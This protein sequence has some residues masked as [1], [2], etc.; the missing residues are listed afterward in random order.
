VSF[1]LEYR[2]AAESFLA[3]LNLDRAGRLRLFHVLH[4]LRNISDAERTDLANRLGPFFVFRRAFRYQGRDLPIRLIVDDSL[5]QYGVL[6]V[7]YADR[8]GP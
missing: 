3:R 5:A 7:I 6:R 8:P 1:L 2:P 4:A